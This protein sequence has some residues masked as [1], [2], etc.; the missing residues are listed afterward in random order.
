MEE[1]NDVLENLNEMAKEGLEVTDLPAE[2]D[3]KESSKGLLYVGMLVGVGVTLGAIEL[4]K[5]IGKAAGKLK[6]RC[7]EKKARKA[8]EG[9]KKDE[10]PTEEFDEEV[11]F[12]EESKKK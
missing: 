1:R 11:D 8:C 2:A 5:C 7:D 3:V 9:C 4:G 6:A 12:T 10:E